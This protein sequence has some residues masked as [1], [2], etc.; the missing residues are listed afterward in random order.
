MIAP[1]W[2]PSDVPSSSTSAQDNVNSAILLAALAA[3]A[4]SMSLESPYSSLLS[5]SCTT[6]ITLSVAACAVT[7]VLALYG[8]WDVGFLN[9]R[10]PLL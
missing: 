6:G 9:H 7:V 2:G 1:C 8:H 3:A 5:G 4:G 10:R